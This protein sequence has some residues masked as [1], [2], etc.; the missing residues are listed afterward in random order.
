MSAPSFFSELKRRQIYRGGV[1]YVVAGWVI[2]QVATTVFPYFEIPSWA[3]RL[4]VVAILL[5]FPIALVA[6]WMFEST[7]PN[8]PETRLHDRR[9]GSRD[10]T[11]VLA[12]L[13]E[14]ERS[15]RARETQ[16]L[17]AALGQLKGEQ[18][19]VQQAPISEAPIAMETLRSRVTDAPAPAPTPP[20]PTAVPVQPARKRRSRFAM[21]MGLAAL[22]IVLSGIWTLVVPQAAFQPAAAAAASGQLAEK[23]VAPGFNQLEDIGVFMLTPLLEELGIPMA[24]ERVFTILL[25]IV[26]FLILR[27]FYRQIRR[28]RVRRARQH[29]Y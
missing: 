12:Q 16:E 11:D 1:M 18:S 10:T 7:L 27:S 22:C 14:A 29:N 17:I 8:D 3:I 24:P 19:R 13:M 21:L 6:L 26:G 28:T 2:V 9:Q 4:L 23:Y 15:E 5:G 20:T 25:V